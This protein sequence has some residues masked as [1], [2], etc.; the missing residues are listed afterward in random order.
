[1]NMLYVMIG[2]MIIIYVPLIMC[3]YAFYNLK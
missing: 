2:L 3:S 1:M